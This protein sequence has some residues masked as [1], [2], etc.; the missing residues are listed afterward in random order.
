MTVKSVMH[1]GVDKKSF[2][3]ITLYYFCAKSDYIFVKI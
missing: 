2:D 1:Q 3:K